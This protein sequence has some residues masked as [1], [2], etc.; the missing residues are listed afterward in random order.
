MAYD[1]KLKTLM[2]SVLRDRALSISDVILSLFEEGYIPNRRKF[3]I[4]SWCQMLNK[5]YSQIDSVNEEQQSK[6]DNLYNKIIKM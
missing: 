1:S 2:L 5:V 6:L 3:D 4:L